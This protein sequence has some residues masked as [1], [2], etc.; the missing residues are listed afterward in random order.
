MRRLANDRLGHVGDVGFGEALVER[1]VLSNGI[2]LCQPVA[3]LRCGVG[4]TRK[5]TG[6]DT[7]SARHRIDAGSILLRGERIDHP[8]NGA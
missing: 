2:D 1:R 5:C 6:D 4:V 8:L 7:R 3:G